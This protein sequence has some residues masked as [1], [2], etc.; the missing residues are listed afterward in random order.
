MNYPDF[1]SNNWLSTSRWEDKVTATNEDPPERM[2]KSGL[3]KLMH[4]HSFVCFTG[5][6]YDISVYNNIFNYSLRNIL[7]Y[8]QNVCL[9]V[10][11]TI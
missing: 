5:K 10:S 4:V 7:I 8:F 9:P 2:F 11:W 3:I 1:A 6:D